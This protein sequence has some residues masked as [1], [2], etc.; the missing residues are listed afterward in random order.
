[1]YLMPPT[2]LR[3]RTEKALA[4]KPPVAPIIAKGKRSL[5][6]A[7]VEILGAVPKRM[8]GVEP[9]IISVG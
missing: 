4:D 8:R 7:L 5:S 1:M 9:P 2:R 3:D 6:G